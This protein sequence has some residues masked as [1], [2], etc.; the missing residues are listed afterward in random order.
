MCQADPTLWIPAVQYMYKYVFAGASRWATRVRERRPGVAGSLPVG[1]ARAR[2]LRGYFLPL[3]KTGGHVDLPRRPRCCWTLY[4]RPSNPQSHIG[5][6]L[7]RCGKSGGLRPAAASNSRK[8]RRPCLLPPPRGSFPHLPK[9]R[10]ANLLPLPAPSGS[11]DTD[12]FSEP[13][14]PDETRAPLDEARQVEPIDKGPRATRSTSS[15]PATI[16]TPT[17]PTWRRE[18]RPGL[19]RRAKSSSSHYRSDHRESFRSAEAAPKAQQQWQ[20]HPSHD[21]RQRRF[22]V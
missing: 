14:Q 22:G 10:C 4:R 2:M 5:S 13:T 1:R 21:T 8:L 19:R 7:G 17:T 18:S 9:Q 20:R 16:S 12:D 15:L 11:P 6:R 3:L